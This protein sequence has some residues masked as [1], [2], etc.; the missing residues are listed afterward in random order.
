MADPGDGWIEAP[1]SPFPI[2]GLTP[3]PVSLGDP[4]DPSIELELAPDA[5]APTVTT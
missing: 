2:P 4:F 3:G 5:F 1:W